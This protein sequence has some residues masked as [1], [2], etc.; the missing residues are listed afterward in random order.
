MFLDLSWC[1]KPHGAFLYISSS[2]LPR[3]K[4]VDA[5]VFIR[6]WKHK[7]LSNLA[8]LIKWYEMKLYKEQL[9]PLCILLWTSRKEPLI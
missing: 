7:E 1:A 4:C 2:G 5:V 3:Q 9:L 6:R 8:K